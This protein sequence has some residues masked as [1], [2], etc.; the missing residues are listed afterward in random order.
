M[1]SMGDAPAQ[2]EVPMCQAAKRK[3]KDATASNQ[4]ER[5]MHEVEFHLSRMFFCF[6]FV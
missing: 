3:K 5:A 1:D 6:F 4:F 2:E